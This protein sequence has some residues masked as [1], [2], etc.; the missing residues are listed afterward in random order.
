[1][2][3]RYPDYDVLANARHWDE[4]DARACSCA[5][6]S[7]PPVR[8]FDAREEADAARAFCDVVLPRTPSRGSRCSRWST[9]KLAD[10]ELDGYRY[11]DMPDDRET[12]RLVAARARR[13]RRRGRLRRAPAATAA[14]RSSSASR[15][16]SCGGLGRAQRRARVVGGDARRARGVLLAPVGVERDR[17]RRPGLPARLH[18]PAAGAAGRE[19]HEARGGVRARPGRSTCRARPCESQ[20]LAAVPRD[21]DSAFLLDV[22]RRGIPGAARMRRYADDDE[23][24]LVIVGAGAGGG[25]ARAAAR[26]PRLADRRARVRPVLGP[27]PRLGLRR[28]RPAQALLDRAARDRRRATRSSWARTTPA[29]AS[30][31]R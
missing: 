16:A 13:R 9:R 24:D 1:M 19:P 20:G 25:G 26:A 29:T 22:H 27:G 28:G 6:S 3:G 7:V 8:F 17:L 21:N 31:A 11:A 23:V 30:A 5:C 10:G 2:H 12:W 4:V 18:A 15:R 14:R